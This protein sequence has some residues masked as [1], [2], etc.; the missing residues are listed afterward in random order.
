MSCLKK[1][2]ATV[3]QSSS[4]HHVLDA[5]TGV[6][7]LIDRSFASSRDMQQTTVELSSQAGQLL[8]AVDRFK[9]PS[10]KTALLDDA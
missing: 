7:A 10:M 8:H 3:E 9:L 4:I 2:G 1:P 5:V 6:S